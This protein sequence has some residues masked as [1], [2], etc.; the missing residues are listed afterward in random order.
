MRE[1]RDLRNNTGTGAEE[2]S[3]SEFSF[4]VCVSVTVQSVWGGVVGRGAVSS[5][6][7]IIVREELTDNT[8]PSP[9]PAPYLCPFPST[10]S[11]F[12]F[13]PCS[14]TLC[15]LLPIYLAQFLWEQWARGARGALKSRRKKEAKPGVQWEHG[16]PGG[17]AE[18]W[19]TDTGVCDKRMSFTANDSHRGDQLLSLQN[20]T[21]ALRQWSIDLAPH[22]KN[23]NLTRLGLKVT[24][25][26]EAVAIFLSFMLPHYL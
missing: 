6:T 25:E 14:F 22:M 20:L 5:R 2:E 13:F 4:F 15:P 11:S 18:R 7:L 12:F 10:M 24:Q 21:H 16:G 19:G 3:E 23:T 26:A 1:A 9:P 8:T 17:W